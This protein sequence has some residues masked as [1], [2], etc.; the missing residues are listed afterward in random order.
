MWGRWQWVVG[1]GQWGLDVC[2]REEELRR[3][4]SFASAGRQAVASRHGEG[5]LRA[6]CARTHLPHKPP[7]RPETIACPKPTALFPAASCPQA[8]HHRRQAH[9]VARPALR[10]GLDRHPGR[11]ASSRAGVRGARGS[12]P[13]HTSVA[14]AARQPWKVGLGPTF[15]R[16]GFLIASQ[17]QPS[18]PEVAPAA[19]SQARPNTPPHVSRLT[20]LH[21][22]PSHPPAR[23][24]PQA[25][26]TAASAS[27]CSTSCRTTRSRPGWRPLPWCSA[28]C[29][30]RAAPSS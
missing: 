30:S 20:P 12:V 22:T 23:A 25:S 11:C 16:T 6:V 27:C 15:C 21:T 7:V 24:A 17:P 26:P 1:C 18:S 14:Q 9:R 19:R 4:L 13:A 5:A 28:C 2:G 10:L 3:H 8:R 29:Y